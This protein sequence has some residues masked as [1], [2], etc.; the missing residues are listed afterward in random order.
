MLEEIIN[1]KWLKIRPWYKYNA[2]IFIFILILY[3]IEMLIITPYMIKNQ[4][5]DRNYIVFPFCIVFIDAIF[6]CRYQPNIF[7]NIFYKIIY[8]LV[9]VTP[10]ILEII[11]FYLKYLFRCKKPSYK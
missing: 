7:S 8:F 11:L 3:C 6:C 2:M 10:C 1:Y 5:N 4:Y 9:Y